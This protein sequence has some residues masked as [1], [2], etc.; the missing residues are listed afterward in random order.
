MWVE[1]LKSERDPCILCC[2]GTIDRTEWRCGCQKQNEVL[3]TLVIK[4][5]HIS[6]SDKHNEVW[7]GSWMGIAWERR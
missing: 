7:S 1:A 3:L 6:A 5:Q 2:E 4:K